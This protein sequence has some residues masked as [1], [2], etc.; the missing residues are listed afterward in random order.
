MS[1]DPRLLPYHASGFELARTNERG[2]ETWCKGVAPLNGYQND[3]ILK[4]AGQSYRSR[5]Y[6]AQRAAQEQ[7]EAFL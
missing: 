4:L 6:R 3:Q 1:D 7:Q 2:I 5:R